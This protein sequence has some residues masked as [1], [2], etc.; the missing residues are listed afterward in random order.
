MTTPPLI[1]NGEYRV[2]RRVGSGGTANVFLAEERATGRQVAM[3]VL[4][5]HLLDDP[6]M[7]GR[8][9]RE[10][11]LLSRLS[12]PNIVRLLRYEPSDEGVVLLLDWVD[13]RRL[14]EALAEGPM[15]T[16]RV[17]RLLRQLAAAITSIHGAGIVH[18]DLKPGNVML[19]GRGEAERV[20]LLDFGIARFSD[21]GLAR[22]QFQSAV[23][24]FTGTPGFMAPEQASGHPAD[25]RSDVYT[26][27]VLAYLML[28]GRMPFSGGSDV[29][30]ISNQL[31]ADPTPF[32]PHDRAVKGS[33]L[34]AVVMRCLERPP[35]RRP[36]DGAALAEVL[37]AHR[38]ARS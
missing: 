1:L 36:A 13:G 28:T 4:R 24:L 26:F 9:A 11:A 8:F 32:A 12:H 20:R 29:E 5:A 7:Q 23:G 17:L 21:P 34:E 6:D 2:L 38:P 37:T 27:G 31:D 10:A 15:E 19:E 3:K 35:E 14:D 18:R 22:D 33:R 30:V 16:G 25:T